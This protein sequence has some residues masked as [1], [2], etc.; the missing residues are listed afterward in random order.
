MLLETRL[1]MNSSTSWS[2]DLELLPLDLL[3]QDRD[4]RLEVG[5]ADVDD[6]ALAEARAQAVLELFEL[7]G[8]PV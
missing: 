6:D 3:A 7:A 5:A 8:L 2:R 4:A 1:A